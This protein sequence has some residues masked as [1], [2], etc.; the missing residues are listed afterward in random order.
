M[1]VILINIINCLDFHNYN[2]FKYP[3]IHNF[4]FHNDLY[5]EELPRWKFDCI[6]KTAFRNC[7]IYI[8]DKILSQS[9]WGPA[10]K[11]VGICQRM[12]STIPFPGIAKQ[13]KVV[14]A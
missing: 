13:T 8:G 14:K 5:K 11:I 4:F 3:I 9:E 1:E 2:N 12:P 6:F 7:I 10:E